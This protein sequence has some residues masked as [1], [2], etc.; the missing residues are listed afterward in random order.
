MGMDFP[1]F[2]SAFER[3]AE[4]IAPTLRP[5]Q[6]CLDA[7]QRQALEGHVRSE[8]GPAIEDHLDALIAGLPT[9]QER[10][11]AMAKRQH[12]RAVILREMVE[13]VC[14]MVHGSLSSAATQHSEVVGDFEAALAGV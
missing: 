4:K 6:M 5:G 8:L 10:R 9:R 3:I 2:L 11:R 13:S 14:E 7:V 1:V 12:A